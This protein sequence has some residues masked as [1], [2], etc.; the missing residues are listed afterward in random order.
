MSS[1]IGQRQTFSETHFMAELPHDDLGS[2]DRSFQRGDKIEV[3]YRMAFPE[4]G[5]R[6]RIELVGDRW[7]LCATPQ[8]GT[9]R[10][11]LGWTQRWLPAIVKELLPNS[12]GKVESVRFQWEVQQW[13]D[14]ATGD[15]ISVTKDPHALTSEIGIQ[16]VRV[17]SVQWNLP[18]KKPWTSNHLYPTNSE[19]GIGGC[20]VAVSF[21]VFFGTKKGARLFLFLVFQRIISGHFCGVGC[22]LHLEV[23]M[24]CC[25][26]SYH[27]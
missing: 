24:G 20:E 25:K 23:S 12:E 22:F 13:Y 3:F 5:G 26:D 18:N 15:H 4:D 14:W 2:L 8:M 7:M 1:L 17:R 19:A 11:R 10:P 21:I 27:V 16:E 6:E 9:N